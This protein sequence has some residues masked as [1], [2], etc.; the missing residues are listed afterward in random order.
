MFNISGINKYTHYDG[1]YLPHN[2]GFDYVGTMLP[3]TLVWDCDST[4]VQV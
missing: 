3:H 4:K 1:Y 2:Q